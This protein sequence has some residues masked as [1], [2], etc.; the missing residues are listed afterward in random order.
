MSNKRHPLMPDETIHKILI[1]TTSRLIGSYEND[2]ILI[3]HAW[4]HFSNSNGLMREEE[5]PVS[6][7]AFVLA[8]KTEGYTKAAGV[9]IPDYSY[10]GDI[11]C[12]LLSVLYGKRFDSHGLLEGSGFYNTPDLSAY[13]N[14][15]NHKL[16]FNSHTARRC[17]NVPLNLEHF[18]TLEKLLLTQD[19][20]QEFKSKLYA[21]CKFYTQAIQICETEPEVAYL[22]LITAGEIISGHYSYEQDEV[23]DAVTL[24]HLAEIRTHVPNG[25]KIARHISGRLLSIK[26][27]FIKSLVSLIGPDFFDQ[28]EVSGE[29]GYF[30]NDDFEKRVG[31]A[32]DLRSKYVH[33]GSPFGGWIKPN[34][35]LDDV[36]LGKPVVPDKE[37]AKTLAIAPTFTGLERVIRYCLLK[38]MSNNGLA[39]LSNIKPET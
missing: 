27:R 19:I 10:I 8:F 32:Y 22:H 31:A 6:R 1:S 20:D 9:V 26:K 13:N 33:T 29:F 16:P 28:R 34:S 5:N 21:A 15:C 7:S 25:D 35:R 36:Q 11:V 30:K 39:E 17:F 3:S 18:K 2:D 38:F 23:L 14:I 4:Q 24:K 37:Y 12:S